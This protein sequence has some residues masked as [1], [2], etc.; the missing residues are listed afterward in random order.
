MTCLSG[1]T[2]PTRSS[3]PRRA[4]TSGHS[5]GG[6]PSRALSSVI[7]ASSLF[8]A[9][10]C[11]HSLAASGGEPVEVSFWNFFGIGIPPGKQSKSWWTSS[12]PLILISTST[13]S[14][15]LS[16]SGSS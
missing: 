10:A 4:Q 13:G 3:T 9:F 2:T 7:L 1:R 8:F 14:T 15:F 12:T 5:R 16:W 11:G 6:V